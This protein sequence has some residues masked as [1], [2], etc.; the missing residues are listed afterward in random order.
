MKSL[1]TLIGG[2]A[3]ITACSDLPLQEGFT[4]SPTPLKADTMYQEVVFERL[5]AE[6]LSRTMMPSDNIQ[7][8]RIY[9]QDDIAAYNY[10][11]NKSFSQWKFQAQEYSK[12][13]HTAYL[14]TLLNLQS[15]DS[16]LDAI[17]LGSP[18]NVNLGILEQSVQEYAANTLHTLEDAGL[19]KTFVDVVYDSIPG[20][21]LSAYR[22]PIEKLRK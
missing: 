4:G 6:E 8:L 14:L 5:T 3:L 11:Y 15:P 10:V 7:M 20:P 22:A 1:A 19:E 9:M 16:L 18:V 17:S 12:R 21:Y 2:M 13:K